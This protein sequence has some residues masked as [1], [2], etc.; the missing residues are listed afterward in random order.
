M[1]EE[2]NQKKSKFSS[3]LNIIMR[4]DSLWKDSHN[5]SRSGEFQK[6]DSDLDRIWLELARDLTETNY[7]DKKKK[8]DEFTEKIKELGGFNDNPPSGFKEPSKEDIK[9]RAKVYSI[10][11]EKQL[12]LARLEN[13]LGKGT[14]EDDD[15]EDDFD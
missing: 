9:K 6:W 4:L 3:G 13:F 2:E 1:S 8:F 11:M 10:L 14:T 7:E 15:D 5:H 12:F